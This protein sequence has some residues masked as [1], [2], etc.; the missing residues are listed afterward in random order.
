EAGATNIRSSWSPVLT[1]ATWHGRPIVFRLGVRGKNGPT[2][3]FVEISA[4]AP[5]RLTV[6][7]REWWNFNVRLFGPPRVEIDAAPEHIVRSDDVMLANQLF[8]HADLVNAITKTIGGTI[9]LLELT[10]GRVRV[11]RAAHSR[12]DADK[13]E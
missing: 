3:A 1:Q 4:A 10:P 7:H 12:D 8:A 11:V 9:D 2:C 6:C 13:L 5:A